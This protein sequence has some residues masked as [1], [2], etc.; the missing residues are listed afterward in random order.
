MVHRWRIS[1][2]RTNLADEYG[3][4]VG[5]LF[6][7]RGLTIHEIKGCAISSVVPSLTQEFIEMSEKYFLQSPL[8]Y[9]PEINIGM[10]INTDYP[11]E[12]GHDL[13]V[14][15]LAARKLYGKPVII[16]GFGTATSFVAVGETGDLEGVAIAPGV[17]IVYERN[18]IT[19]KLLQE[20]GVKTI[21]IPSSELSRGRGGPRCMSMPL[22]RE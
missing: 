3:V 22:V 18:S 2:D 14:N 5:D 16:V 8:I 6:E 15:A 11:S 13:I 17:V 9:S 19:N 10:K 21:I 12:V 4:L 20:H 7:T 1:T